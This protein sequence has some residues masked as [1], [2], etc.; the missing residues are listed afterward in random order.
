[1]PYVPEQGRPQP[2]VS[3]VVKLIREAVKDHGRA[4]VLCRSG[5]VRRGVLERLRDAGVGWYGVEVVTLEAAARQHAPNFVAPEGAAEPAEPAA[6]P[7]DHEWGASLADR[8]KLRGELRR[9]VVRARAL[10]ELSD[11][12]LPAAIEG[13]PL[14]PL[15]DSEWGV[16]ESVKGWHCLAA[17]IKKLGKAVIA[18]G[19][20]PD[21]T[22]T[23]CGRVDAV[24]RALLQPIPRSQWCSLAD[25]GSFLEQPAEGHPAFTEQIHVSDVAA[26]SRI[27]V[28]EIA[29]ALRSNPSARILV[30]CAHEGTMGRFRAACAR[31]GVPVAPHHADRIAH[32]GLASLCHDLLPVFLERGLQK[33]TRGAIQKLLASPMLRR[34]IE[35][36]QAAGIRDQLGALAPSVAA[37]EAFRLANRDIVPMLNA[38]RRSAALLDGWIQAIDAW[39]TRQ[40][41]QPPDQL[42]PERARSRARRFVSARIAAGRLNS[43]RDCAERGTFDALADFLSVNGV[44]DAVDPAVRALRGGLRQLGGRKVCFEDFAEMLESTIDGGRLGGGVQVLHYHEYDGRGADLLV[45]LDLHSKGIASPP[46]GDAFLQSDGLLNAFGLPAP[47]SEVGERIRLLRWALRR[48]EGTAHGRSVAVVTHRDATSRAVVP[49]LELGLQGQVSVQNH[50]LSIEHIPE[51]LARRRLT[52]QPANNQQTWSDAQIDAEWIRAHWPL[53]RLELPRNPAAGLNLKTDCLADFLEAAEFRTERCKPY[54]GFAGPSVDVEKIRWSPSSIEQ[55]TG[56]LYRGYLAR[57]LGL[58]EER[59]LTEDAGADEIGTA[60]HAAIESGIAAADGDVFCFIVPDAQ[61]SERRERFVRAAAEGFK[62]SLREQMGLQQD[63]PDVGVDRTVQ[64]WIVHLRRFAEARIIGFSAARQA[65]TAEM[66]KRLG[67]TNPESRQ[68]LAAALGVDGPDTRKKRI[69]AAVATALCDSADPPTQESILGQ[70]F[71]QR[72]EQ[73]LAETKGCTPGDL[74]GLQQL[75]PMIGQRLH[76]PGGFRRYLDEA[77]RQWIPMPNEAGDRVVIASERPLGVNGMSLQ[78]GGVAI[79]LRGKLDAVVRLPGNRLEICDFK[80][81]STPVKSEQMFDAAVRPQLPIYALAARQ[82]LVEGIPAGATVDSV[83]IDHIKKVGGARADRSVIAVFDEDGADKLE[84]FKDRLRRVLLPVLQGSDFPLRPHPGACPLLGGEQ[85]RYCDFKHVCRLRNSPV[86][87]ED[88][89]APGH[90]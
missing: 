52:Q 69:G 38:A 25:D 24:A 43:L 88:P 39:A 9:H 59:E 64:R 58:R 13:S 30:L 77:Q 83:A 73:A 34:T 29:T 16:D 19:F 63:A 62:Q 12:Q 27:A 32:H 47:E 44:K 53:S 79:Q 61:V 3:E 67:V 65:R 17:R 20:D 48:I 60:L 87:A 5:S 23:H 35:N 41:E 66:L 57:V 54:L 89:Q 21:E 46:R 14:G 71:Q 37:N 1:M 70:E 36:D 45:S 51:N 74:A 56:C 2:D 6:F 22:F 85:G 15:V 72:A 31:S 82:G 11:G 80:S 90:E 18:C 84:H 8:P 10:R 42:Q 7:A 81:S 75:W 50:A 33:V 86:L 78:L 55:F 28:R 40:T 68:A 4:L 26:E 49:P 76:A